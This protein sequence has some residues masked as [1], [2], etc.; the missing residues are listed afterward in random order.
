MLGQ[1]VLRLCTS[2]R[3]STLPQRYKQSGGNIHTSFDSLQVIDENGDAVTERLNSCCCIRQLA[4]TASEHATILAN[5]EAHARHAQNPE[6]C[7]AHALS[8]SAA[9]WILDTWSSVRRSISVI[10]MASLW[11]TKSVRGTPST[12]RVSSACIDIGR[13]CDAA[14]L[15]FRNK[16]QSPSPETCSK[17]KRWGQVS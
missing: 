5:Q 11:E 4:F 13:S 16:Y 9:E 6:Y 15:V 17:H 14:A 8:E 2:Q 10:A 3:R 7:D 12:S 1:K